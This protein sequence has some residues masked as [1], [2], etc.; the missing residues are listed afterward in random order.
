MKVENDLLKKCI[1]Y[2]SNM[3]EVVMHKLGAVPLLHQHW[4]QKWCC[5]VHDITANCK[6]DWHCLKKG[7]L[8]IPQTFPCSDFISSS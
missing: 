5:D 2:L 3:V 7:K 4:A 6:L 1:G 8:D